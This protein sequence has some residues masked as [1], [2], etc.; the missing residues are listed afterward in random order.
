MSAAEMSKQVIENVPTPGGKHVK[1]CPSKK[2]FRKGQTQKLNLE[3]CSP[4]TPKEYVHTFTHVGV[5]NKM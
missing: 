5:N 2:S 3:K 1:K 4:T